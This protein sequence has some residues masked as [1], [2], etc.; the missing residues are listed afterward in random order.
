MRVKT[1]PTVAVMVAVVALLLVS[2]P[3]VAACAPK[4]APSSEAPKV[5]V[6]VTLFMDATGPYAA[7]L[8]V[9]LKGL[10]DE[11]AERNKE[12]GIDGHPIELELLDNAGDLKKAVTIYKEIRTR[13][14]KPYIMITGHTGIDGMLKD[15]YRKDEIPVVFA[16]AAV[17]VL[18]PSD[19]P[20]WVFGT[21]PAYGNFFGGTLDFIKKDWETTKTHAGNPR[22]AILTWDNAFG[23]DILTKETEAYAKHIGV[24]I[25][26][27]EFYP[28]S[29]MTTVDQILRVKAQNPDWIATQSLADTYSVV[30]K[31]AVAQGLVPPKVRYVN[32][33]AGTDYMLSQMAP[34]ATKVAM[35]YAYTV[36][37]SWDMTDNPMV[38]RAEKTFKENNRI[39]SD[40]QV[41][42]FAGQK[43][44]AMI[45]EAVKRA[46]NKVGYENLSGRAIYDAFCSFDKVDICGYPMS[47]GPVQRSPDQMQMM[48][49]NEAGKMLPVSDYFRV[50]DLFPNGKDVPPGTYQ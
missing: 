41:V 14:K 36:Y 6:K 43:W 19:P 10:S 13:E 45:A 31:D 46:A 44:T 29:I 25:V 3:V 49:I 4:A 27:K 42:Y 8:A 9:Y 35:P 7:T 20:G 32:C 50:P 48:R 21:L 33:F 38:K 37:P 30:L 23:R 2:L 12:G 18:A 47:Y 26:A 40:R 24:D 5:P 28:V 11:V 16:V 1:K 17:N 22:L 34:D 39:A 15:D